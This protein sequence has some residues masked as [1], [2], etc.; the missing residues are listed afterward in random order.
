[1]KRKLLFLLSML[2][3]ISIGCT[4]QT[5]QGHITGVVLDDEDEPLSGAILSIGELKKNVVADKNGEFSFSDIPENN[6][7]ITVK[8]MGYQTQTLKV[9]AAK[10]NAKKTIVHMKSESQS[11]KEVVAIGKSEA[12]RIREDKLC[13]SLGSV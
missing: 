11:L 5:E 13:R 3:L 7:T 1:M 2:L 9:N 10:D 12:R 6:Y 8:Y 4:A